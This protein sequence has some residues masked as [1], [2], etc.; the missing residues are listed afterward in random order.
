MNGSN[1]Y[2][3]AWYSHELNSANLR[4]EISVNIRKA[5]IVSANGP[6]PAGFYSD[7]T[8]FRNRIKEALLEDEFV[9]AD[10]GYFDTSCI[11]PPG[12]EHA[13]HE[14]YLGIEPRHN[15]IN[16]RV[17]QFAVLVQKFRHSVSY[18]GTCFLVSSIIA[19]IA[20]E[21]KTTFSAT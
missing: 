2:S 13:K 16:K 21:E 9:I 10:R 4:Y 8:I 15:V 7:V 14:T 20:L 3:S 19:A 11:Q 1:P 17:K 18:H 5:K 12:E 6:W